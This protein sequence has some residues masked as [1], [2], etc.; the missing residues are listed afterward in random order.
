MIAKS[1]GA[2]GERTETINDFEQA[3]KNAMESMDKGV[4]Y[5]I[6]AIIESTSFREGS[7]S[8]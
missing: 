8:I 4:P 2:N 3:I 1:F 5:L 6:N 7:I